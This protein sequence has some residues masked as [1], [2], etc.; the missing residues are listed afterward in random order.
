[1]RDSARRGARTAPSAAQFCPA[2]GMRCAKTPRASSSCGQDPWPR[3]V[4]S[5]VATH[6]GIPSAGHRDRAAAAALR[7][8]RRGP[9]A[10]RL[11]GGHHRELHG[12]GRQPA[13]RAARRARALSRRPA[14]RFDV[15]GVG[16]SA[17]RAGTWTRWT[18]WRARSSRPGSRI[19]CAGPAS[20]ATSA[21]DLWPLPV[22]RRGAAARRGAH[23]PGAGTAGAAD[24][25]R[26]RRPA[27]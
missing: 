12:R 23:R 18:R 19:T 9:G 2:P 25:G 21:H 5:F 17:G 6:A 10:R 8:G 7:G 16:R 1:M 3:D 14:R 27:T 4:V 24:P 22:H 15:A 13:A 11:A 26:E 20:A